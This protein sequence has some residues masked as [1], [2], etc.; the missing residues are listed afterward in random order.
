M[1]KRATNK[2]KNQRATNKQKTKRSLQDRATSEG[3][4]GKRPAQNQA[5]NQKK[6]RKGAEPRLRAGL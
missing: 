5:L 1:A 2:T 4:L 6:Q 3:R